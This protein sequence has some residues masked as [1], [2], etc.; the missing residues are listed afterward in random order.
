[1]SLTSIDAALSG[2]SEFFSNGLGN[3]SVDASCDLVCALRHMAP[4]ATN[5]IECK[6]GSEASDLEL[7]IR[8]FTSQSHINYCNSSFNHT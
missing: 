8:E 6:R 2:L 7:A 5:V 3:F 4:P 1:M